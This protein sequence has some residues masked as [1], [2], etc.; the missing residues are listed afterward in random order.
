MEAAGIGQGLV[1]IDGYVVVVAEVHLHVKDGVGT[2]QIVA[3]VELQTLLE[4]GYLLAL[5]GRLTLLAF[6]GGHLADEAR[7]FGI[8]QFGQ[9]AGHLDEVGEAELLARHGI[10]ALEV[11]GA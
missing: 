6:L 3:L 10:F 8:G 11:D 4:E 2:R 1:E 9:T 5:H 7:T